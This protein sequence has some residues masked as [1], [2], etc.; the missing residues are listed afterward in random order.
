[1]TQYIFIH[2]K[3]SSVDVV[4]VVVTDM[5]FCQVLVPRFNSLH[6]INWKFFHLIPCSE[7]L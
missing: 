5:P 3:Y 2:K 1:M 7:T 4:S 6:K